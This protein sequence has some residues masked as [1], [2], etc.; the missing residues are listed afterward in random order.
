MKM[1]VS[2]FGILVR[3]E[4]EV[5]GSEQEIQYDV[6]SMSDLNDASIENIANDLYPCE[7]CNGVEEYE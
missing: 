4:C 3:V 2:V 7:E 1:I 6:Y 5:C